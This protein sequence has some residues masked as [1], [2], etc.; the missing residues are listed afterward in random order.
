[1]YVTI[2]LYLYCKSKI[3]QKKIFINLMEN[4]IANKNDSHIR[5]IIYDKIF[6]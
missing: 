2:S 3:K 1:M 4:Y 5:E 6:K